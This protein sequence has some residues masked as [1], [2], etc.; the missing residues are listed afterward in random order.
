M[1]DAAYLAFVRLLSRPIFR[2]KSLFC[3]LDDVFGIS[4][5][6][7]ILEGVFDILNRIFPL[8]LVVT[9]MRYAR[10]TEG[11]SEEKKT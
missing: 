7:F 8:P 11:N 3:I 10:P 6:I 5:S 4:G 1:R 9:N 2:P